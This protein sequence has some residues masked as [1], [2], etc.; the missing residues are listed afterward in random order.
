MRSL[1]SRARSWLN[2]ESSLAGASPSIMRMLAIFGGGNLVASLLHMASGLFTARLTT[3]EVLGTFR[4]LGLSQQY[5]GVLQ[6]GVTNGLGRELPY[7]IGKGKL[8]EALLL[9]STARVWSLLVGGVV[10]LTLLAVG[11]WQ[12]MQGSTE[13]AVGWATYALTAGLL[14]FYGQTYPQMVHRSLNSF[15]SIT[16]AKMVQ[17]TLEAVLLVCVALWGFYGLCLSLL[18]SRLASSLIM[19]WTLPVRVQ[20]AWNWQRF[21]HMVKVGLPIFGV[22]YLYSLWA[23]LDSTLVLMHLGA[24]GLGLYQLAAV[25]GATLGLLPASLGEI[26][27]P[28]MATEYGRT[29]SVARVLSMTVRPTA[30][31]TAISV[32]LVIV[33]WTLLPAAVKFLIPQY[34]SGIGAA[35]WSLLTVAISFLQSPNNAFNVLQKQGLYMVAIICGIGLYAGSLYAFSRGG[36]RIEA[37]PQAMAIGKGGFI[38]I[39]YGMLYRLWRA[40]WQAR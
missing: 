20:L 18:V 36:L 12:L 21:W 23:T 24:E 28:S 32:P 38:L 34:A 39:C 31:I 3:P 5:S 2:T 27:Y 9:T 40:E 1:T 14:S 8:E 37:F 6:L 26:I 25:V 7:F 30:T 15:G 22:G 13:L 19:L 35:Q 4:G 17:S 29:G 10:T 11:L 16:K 33:G